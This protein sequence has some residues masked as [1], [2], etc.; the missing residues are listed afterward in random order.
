MLGFGAFANAQT[1]VAAWD[2]SQ[3]ATGGFSTLDNQ[4]LEGSMTANYSGFDLDDGTGFVRSG[5][6]WVGA[7]D[8]GELHYDG[9][10]GSSQFVLNDPNR[11]GNAS[12][13]KFGGGNAGPDE[14]TENNS[15]AGTTLGSNGAFNVLDSQGQP[16]T[17]RFAFGLNPEAENKSFTYAISLTQDTAFQQGSDWVF[18]FAGRSELDDES[19]DISWEYSTD[20][21]SF[22][23]S[24]I[25]SNIGGNEQL[26][27]V[28]L[29]N[30]EALD[31]VSDVFLRG[32]AEN[33]DGGGDGFT[34]SLGMDNF[35]AEA[36]PEPSTYAAI[37][38]ALAL[39]AAVARRRI[40]N[41]A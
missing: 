24:G 41:K 7:A 19:G 23:D 14:L 13:V 33:F 5:P 4:T 39:G 37:A 1:T 10:F 12:D 40:R 22:T 17:K 38:G 16:N 15:Q 25:T 3:N 8:L 20:G 32:T 26:F 27:T 11:S 2:F 18:K 34:G 9:Q 36:V 21:S 28:D 29:S 30:V 35:S 31:G 6:N